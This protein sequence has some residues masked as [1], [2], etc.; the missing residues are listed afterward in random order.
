M[1]SS[2][3]TRMDKFNFWDVASVY[4]QLDN[5]THVLGDMIERQEDKDNMDKDEGGR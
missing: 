1:T 2:Q 3:M 5:L 4:G